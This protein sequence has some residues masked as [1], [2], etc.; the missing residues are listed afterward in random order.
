MLHLHGESCGFYCKYGYVANEYYA[1]MFENFLL[2]SGSCLTLATYPKPVA[3]KSD[4]DFVDRFNPTQNTPS[5][6]L[7][8]LP[9]A[10]MF[11][12]GD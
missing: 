1:A 2:R 8:I 11:V 9:D 7:L 6:Q 3:C 4:T 12:C 5:F 10:Q